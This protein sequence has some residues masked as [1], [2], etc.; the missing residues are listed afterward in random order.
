[1]QKCLELQNTLEWLFYRKNSTLHTNLGAEVDSGRTAPV[2]SQEEGEQGSAYHALGAVF[3]LGLYLDG[4][5][6][7]RPECQAVV[8][9]HHHR[10]LQQLGQEQQGQQEDP[11]CTQV[12]ATGSPGHLGSLV[13]H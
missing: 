1:M 10:V 4:N 5:G 9:G 13:Q 12:F 3:C 8:D 11:C 6:M 2:K 7:L